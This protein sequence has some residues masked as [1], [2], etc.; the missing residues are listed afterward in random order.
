MYV[1]AWIFDFYDLL[2]QKQSS[3]S[4]YPFLYHPFVQPQLSRFHADI[5]QGDQGTML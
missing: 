3:D 2:V 5:D 4:P 1:P